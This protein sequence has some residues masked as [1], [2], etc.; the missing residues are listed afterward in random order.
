MNEEKRQFP[1]LNL[2]VNVQWDKITNAAYRPPQTTSAM[3]DISA[4]GIRLILNDRI[5]AGDILDLNIKLSEE[6]IIHVK[7]RVV[8]I[9]KYAK[10][11]EYI[12]II[13]GI[14]LIILGILIFT[15]TLRLV[16]NLTMIN[17]VLLGS[18]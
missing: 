14:L 10:A 5:R 15:Q 13:F 18:G 9:D 1:R 8:W 11:F 2:N 3:K 6:K 17:S 16:A 7:G 4:G 12:N